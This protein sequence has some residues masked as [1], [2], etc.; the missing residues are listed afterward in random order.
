VEVID[1]GR[2]FDPGR[3][4][5]HRYGLREAIRGRMRA[6]GG[7]AGVDSSPGQGTRITLTWP[8]AG[9]GATATAG[10]GVSGGGVSGGGRAGGGMSAAGS[11]AGGPDG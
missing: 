1:C 6:V 5:A 10:G 7:Q 4:P 8:A 2:G 9:A 11:G 3:V